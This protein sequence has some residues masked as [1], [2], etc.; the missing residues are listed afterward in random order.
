MWCALLA[1]WYVPI[2][3]NP[4]IYY[5]IVQRA[6]DI[7]ARITAA[8]KAWNAMRS[9]LLD[10]HTHIDICRKLYMVI[11]VNILLWGCDSWALLSS[12]FKK[13]AAFHNRC[14]PRISGITLWHCQHYHIAMQDVFE[15]CVKML[16]IDKIVAI[17]QLRLLQNVAFLKSIV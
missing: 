15:K 14:A 10:K 9:V 5:K 11:P 7:D 8:T 1:Y 3:V 16:P 12:H 2:R 13:L 6:F 17:R 4:A